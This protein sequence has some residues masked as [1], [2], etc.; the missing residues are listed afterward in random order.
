MTAMDRPSGVT[1][2]AAVA[3]ITGVVDVLAGLGDI[4]IAGGFLSD[5]GFGDTIDGIMTAIGLALVAV[6]ILGLA[7]GYGLWRGRDWALADHEALGERVHRRRR[8][9]RRRVAAERHAHGANPCRH[10]GR[11]SSGCRRC[12]RA[13]VPLPARGEGGVRASLIAHRIIEVGRIGLPVGGDVLGASSVP[14]SARV[15]RRSGGPVRGTGA[16]SVGPGHRGS[17]KWP[18]PGDGVAESPSHR[19]GHRL[20]RTVAS[21][22]S[23]PCRA[24]LGRRCR[25]LTTRGRHR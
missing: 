25:L 1:A 9:G 3:A 15:R 20:K 22:S 11:R 19:A 7:T 24:R 2:L 14:A 21:Q 4:A 5:H 13:L 17:S 16:H 18:G 6:G 8:R 10:L 23:P 12:H